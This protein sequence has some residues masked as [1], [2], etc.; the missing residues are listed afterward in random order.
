MLN[1][2]NVLDYYFNTNKHIYIAFLLFEDGKA[3]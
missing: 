2:K 1:Y 3:V